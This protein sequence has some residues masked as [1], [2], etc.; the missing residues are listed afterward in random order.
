[1]MGNIFPSSSIF[2]YLRHSQENYALCPPSLFVSSPAFHWACLGHLFLYVG[3]F[4]HNN[5]Q[6]DIIS[7]LES[8]M[9]LDFKIIIAICKS[10]NSDITLLPLTQFP[11]STENY[12][13]SL[14]APALRIYELTHSIHR[15]LSYA[16]KSQLICH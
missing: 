9:S 10:S 2:F 14:G 6:L 16:V 3:V 4:C 15:Q 11:M 1:M 12:R 7:S 8:R 5:S 13:C